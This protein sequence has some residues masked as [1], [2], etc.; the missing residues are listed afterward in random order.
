MNLEYPWSGFKETSRGVN[1]DFT[2][3]KLTL[4]KKSPFFKISLK[5]F[6][7]FAFKSIYSQYNESLTCLIFVNLAL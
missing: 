7:Y 2:V 6:F 4:G 5:I 3:S 1:F